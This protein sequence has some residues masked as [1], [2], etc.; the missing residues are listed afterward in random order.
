M[1]ISSTKTL[2][3]IRTNKVVLGWGDVSC[4]SIRACVSI[5][6]INL[7]DVVRSLS[8]VGIIEFVEAIIQKHT[9]IVSGWKWM[10]SGWK[11]Q[12]RVPG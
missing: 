5:Q 9:V 1:E 10:W 6:K 12:S 11:P 3:L 2:W 4:V 8:T 7:T